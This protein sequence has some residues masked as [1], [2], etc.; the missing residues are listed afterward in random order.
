MRTYGLPDAKRRGFALIAAIGTL[1]VLMVFAMA[2]AGSA[3]FT[4]GFSRA[5]TADQKLGAALEEGAGF[6]AA[7]ADIATGKATA[8]IQPRPGAKDDVTVTATVEQSVDPDLLGQAL[9]VRDG[10]LQVRLEAARSGA[11]AP[12]RIAVY[13]INGA[14]NRRAPILLQERRP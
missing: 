11:A 13:L 2:A 14:G 7:G 6:L 1:A 4:L 9:A 10:D 8:L 5:R 3:E 12:Q